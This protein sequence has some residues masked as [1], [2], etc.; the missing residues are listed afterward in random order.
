MP[1]PIPMSHAR[2]STIAASASSGANVAS[3]H[4][5]KPPRHGAAVNGGRARRARARRVDRCDL[6]LERRAR[7]RATAGVTDARRGRG[8]LD[9][10]LARRRCRAPRGRRR[11][12]ARSNWWVQ[13]QC[14]IGDRPRR[15]CTGPTA[16]CPRAACRLRARRR[17]TWPTASGSASMSMPV[18]TL[19]VVVERDLEV[20][21]VVL[22][23]AP[24][25][26][27]SRGAR[28]GSGVG[29]GR[30]DRRCGPSARRRVRPPRRGQSLGG[31]QLMT[32]VKMFFTTGLARG[33][34]LPGGLL[35][36]ELE[37]AAVRLLLLVHVDDLRRA[38]EDVADLRPAEVLEAPARRG[39][40]RGRGRAAS[41]SAV[42]R[43]R[44]CP[45]SPRTASRTGTSAAPARRRR[46][47]PSSSSI[48]AWANTRTGPRSMRTTCVPPLV[49]F[50][51]VSATFAP[52]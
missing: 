20:V 7:R 17:G 2:R 10:V 51:S 47:R 43:R 13:C 33:L 49:P 14:G 6:P 3:A 5:M 4:R 12:P 30:R 31:R 11:D 15:R 1:R 28:G 38:L 18:T 25:R 23:P 50:S 32:S 9:V 52:G 27:P 24:H 34:V 16:P 36:V 22:E 37:L 21:E 19:A 41:R 40:S 26:R 39:G 46:R 29:T 45:R 35:H 44:P 42:R 8:E 48:S